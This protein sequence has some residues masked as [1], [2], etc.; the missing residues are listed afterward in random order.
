MSTITFL[1]YTLYRPFAEGCGRLWQFMRRP[2]WSTTWWTSVLIKASNCGDKDMNKSLYW[3]I[4]HQGSGT[5]SKRMAC[6]HK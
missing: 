6:C 1:L 5:E 2:S 4:K 3:I